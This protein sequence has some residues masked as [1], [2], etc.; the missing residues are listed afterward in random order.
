MSLR[1][2]RFETTACTIPESA[3]PRISAHSTSQVIPNANESARHSSCA[4][5]VP[6]ST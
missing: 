2:S 4:M 3:N 6:S 1:I 5:L